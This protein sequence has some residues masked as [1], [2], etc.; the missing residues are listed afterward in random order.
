M[1]NVYNYGF[2][3]GIMHLSRNELLKMDFVRSAQ[4]LTKLP[5]NLCADKLFKSIARIRMNNGSFTF[6]DLLLQYNE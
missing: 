1:H 3:L 6:E 4:Y 2:S 5:D